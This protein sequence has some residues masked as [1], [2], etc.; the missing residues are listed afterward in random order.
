ML[1]LFFLRWRSNNQKYAPSTGLFLLFI[2]I[3]LHIQV[4]GQYYQLSIH[5]ANTQ[6][7]IENAY[8]YNTKQEALAVSDSFGTCFIGG[9]RIT[10][11]SI[12]IS[13]IG[14]EVCQVEMSALSKGT[15]NIIR[16][17]QRTYI[18]SEVSITGMEADEIV[19]KA[20]DRIPV[21][22][23]SLFHDTTCLKVNFDFYDNPNSQLAEFRGQVALTDDSKELFGALYSIDKRVFHQAYYKYSPELSPDT[24][25]VILFI[26]NHIPM[27][28]SKGVRFQLD[29]MVKDGEM[30]AYKISFSKDSRYVNFSGYMLI[31]SNDYAITHIN[32][33]RGACLKWIAATEKGMGMI[34]TN[35]IHHKISAA[36]KKENLK[37]RFSEGSVNMLFNRVK[38]KKEITH[39]TYDL[40]IE[41]TTRE[42]AN[43]PLM[44]KKANELF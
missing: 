18:L 11:D 5:D 35:L 33:T 41:T 1:V 37:Y 16:L 13:H 39:N 28:K 29:G 8:V 9:K 27:L 32:Y 30:E 25:Y 38:K 26:S 3:L 21:N 17:R 19:R 4:R 22:Y 6:A 23:H 15:A 7:P 36:F 14:Y 31:N 10:S 43:V 44:F 12:F 2:F 20:I 42:Q 24:F 40:N 34:Y